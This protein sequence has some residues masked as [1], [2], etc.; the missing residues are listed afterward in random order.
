MIEK[1]LKY[2][3]NGDEIF[4]EL[5]SKDGYRLN[6]VLIPSGK[7]FPGHPID[8]NVTILVVCGI[9]TL[10]LEGQDRNYYGKGSVV[11]IPIGIFSELGNTGQ[12]TTEVFVIKS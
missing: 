1:I 4:E 12:E 3:V 11:E 6:H 10:K 2:T 8:A 7:I 5:V 9:L